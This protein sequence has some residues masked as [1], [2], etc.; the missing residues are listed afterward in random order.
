MQKPDIFGI[1]KCLEPFHNCTPTL[2]QNPAIFTK[3]GKP[4]VILEIRNLGILT[5]LEYP[6]T[7][8]YL[9]FVRYSEPSQKI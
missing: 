2:I 7:L 5:I 6:K 3:I 9:N 8:A 1:L 4:S